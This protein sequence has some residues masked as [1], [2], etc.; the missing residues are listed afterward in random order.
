MRR[1]IGLLVPLVLSGAAFATACGG[2]SK[3]VTIPG[4]GQVSTSNKIPSDFPSDFP[5]YSGAKVVG[6]VKGDQKG[7][8]G[9]Y[10]TWETGD[11]A[12]KVTTFFKDAF[13]K[14]PWKSESTIESNGTVIL[15]A[16]KDAK[17]AA[18]TVSAANN[19]TTIGVFLG[20]DN[21]LSGTAPTKTGSGSASDNKTATAQASRDAPDSSSSQGSPTASP[22]PPEVT[23]PKDFPKDRAPLPSDARVTSSTS[24][25]QGGSKSYIITYYTKSTPEAAADYFS[26]EMPKHGWVDS[27]TSNTNG[28]YF[29][30]FTSA[31]TSGSTND[32]LTVTAMKS[33]TPGYT[34]VSVSVSLTA[35]Q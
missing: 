25:G 34:Q 28:E 19:K 3:T 4:G 20:D 24:F 26:K 2:D 18:L 5:V 15:S 33:D 32:G 35:A 23:L 30:T 27:F 22:L 9:F 14:G 11:P 6:S 21:S 1:Y 8:Q 10:V 17:S 12:D 13:A 16:K 29:V 7:Q 31:A